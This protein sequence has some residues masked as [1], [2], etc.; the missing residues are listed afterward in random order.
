M[1]HHTGEAVCVKLSPQLQREQKAVRLIMF[2]KTSLPGGP[3]TMD[4]SCSRLYIFCVAIAVLL[5]TF[6]S[7]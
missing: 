2:R 5:V 7:L 3:G 6:A 1:G 4:T